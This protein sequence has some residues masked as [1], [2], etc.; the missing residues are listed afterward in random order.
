[1]QHSTEG[2][3]PLRNFSALWHK[4]L[5]TETFDTPSRSF[6]K[7]FA[8]RN[9]LKSSTEGWFPYQVF[10]NCETKNF[11]RKLLILPHPLL[12][13]NRCQKFFETQHRRVVP[14]P[15]CSAL[16]DKKFSTEIFIPPSPSFSKPFRYRKFSETQHR[17]V[18]P[19]PTFS[20]LWQ[21][22]L[23]TE[24][25]DIPSRSFPNFFAARNFLKSSTEGWFPYHLFR[26]CETKNFPRKLLILLPPLFL[27][28]RCQKFCETQHRRV[29]HLPN[30]SALWDKKF[31]TETFDTPSP[32]FS[33]RS[34]PA[35]LR[36][37][38]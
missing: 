19:L 33:K 3:I 38:A 30:F 28:F 32:S 23:W 20:A 5:W 35:I 12:Q 10:R 6:P 9:F 18:V 22:K 13:N 37:T 26:N 25:F 21:K 17:R 36:N 34:L 4:K 16:W 31:W 11:P 1:M 27:N 24:T 7:F 8:A 15:N 14:L 2:L 29:V